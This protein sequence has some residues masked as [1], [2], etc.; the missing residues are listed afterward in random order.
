M[1]EYFGN[2][3]CPNQ[4]IKI[5]YYTRKWEFIIKFKEK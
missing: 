5:K 2:T 3:K 4:G 1:I